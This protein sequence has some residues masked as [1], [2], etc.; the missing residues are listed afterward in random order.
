MLPRGA[1]RGLDAG[2]EERVQAA[3]QLAEVAAVVGEA[4]R[5]TG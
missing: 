2:E 3:L 4:P 5:L 1:A